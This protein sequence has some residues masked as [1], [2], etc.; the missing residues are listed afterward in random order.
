MNPPPKL[1]LGKHL[2]A[3]STRKSVVD[4]YKKWNGSL[5]DFAAAHQVPPSTV[6]DWVTKEAMGADNLLDQRMNGGRKVALPSTIAAWCF[7]YASDHPKASLTTIYTE[8]SKMAEKAN[9]STFSYKQVR[10]LFDR[11]PTDMRR[12]IADGQRAGFEK[13]GIVA[14]RVEAFPNQHWQMDATELD[15]W[16][17]DMATGVWFHPWMTSV[18]DGY[19]RV[20]MAATYHRDEP[21]TADSLITLK[22][23]ILSKGY[24]DYPFFGLPQAISTDNH[25]IYRSAD[26]LDA[27]RRLNIT[28]D[29]IPNECPSANG[30]IERWFNSFKY[31]LLTRLA[32]YAGQ[33]RGLAKAKEGAVPDSLM[34]RLIRKFIVN[35]YHLREHR[36]LQGTPWEH[37]HE[38]LE[39]AHGLIVNPAEVEDAIKLR[40][41]FK[42]ARDGILIEPGRHYTG[43][44]LGGLVDEEITVLVSPEGR[45]LE[46]PAYYRLQ[47]IGELRCMEEDST[48][49]DEIRKERLLRSIDIQ[50]LASALSARIPNE[51]VNTP[52]QGLPQDG[53]P[54][55]TPSTPATTPHEVPPLSPVA[56]L[57]PPKLIIVPADKP[58]TIGQIPSLKTGDAEP[59]GG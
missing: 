42:V 48:L 43:T 18:I 24:T 12:I 58:E 4:N 21:T 8:V 9:L 16:T 31:G 49:S 33:H 32:G 23:A 10:L 44:C 15:S 52:V 50:R 46:V 17:L 53:P 3:Y 6:K 35:E 55:S 20:I 25:A 11:T 28:R 30:K 1:A 29:P 14:R 56:S 45:D 26:F 22:N 2:E 13:A 41:D 40:R 51:G 38:A 39:H 47:H 37:W 36:E 59:Q 34:P 27:L 57:P 54:P 19:S 5:K 7:C